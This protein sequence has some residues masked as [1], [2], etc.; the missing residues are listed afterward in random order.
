M[1]PLRLHIVFDKQKK[2]QH[3]SPTFLIKPLAKL[4]VRSYA[5]A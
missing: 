5:R 3:Y 4:Q 2:K 1:L